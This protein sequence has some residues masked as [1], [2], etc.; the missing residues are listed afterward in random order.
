MLWQKALGNRP[1]VEAR[2]AACSW[3]AIIWPMP[4]LARRAAKALPPEISMKCR[5]NEQSPTIWPTSLGDSLHRSHYGPYD[6]FLM[7]RPSPKLNRIKMSISD[8]VDD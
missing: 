7:E 2:C 4:T 8:H 3:V 1:V 6:I 5:E